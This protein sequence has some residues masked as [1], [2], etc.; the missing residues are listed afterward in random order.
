[1]QTF[2][3]FKTFIF[4]LD[5]TV[6]CWTNLFPRVK[7]VIDKLNNSGKQVLFVTNNTLVTRKD[8]A[9]R[10]NAFGI[11][12]KEKNVLNPSI[13]IA[14]QIKKKG[15]K[16]IVF[17]EALKK[18]L[19]KLG[20]KIVEKPPADFLVVGYDQKFNDRKLRI[21][22]EA[23]EKGA[24]FLISARGK[25][26]IYG[27]KVISGTGVVVDIIEK[28]SG[29]KATLLGKPSKPFQRLVELNVKSSRKETALFGDELKS[30]VVLGKNA[31]YFTV[32][33]RTGVDKKAKGKIKP[34]L[35]LNS[36]A[37]IRL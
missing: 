2:D 28:M 18:D 4:D 37:D 36:V 32:L 26:F 21:G 24:K 7:E 27:K 10:L 29:K 34:V 3:K 22:V 12:A 15:G 35:V 8:L 25:H 9:K 33:V 1:M 16:A 23:L 19:K 14:K 11:E 31:G 17:C 20:I 13:L 30:D 6:W 5:G